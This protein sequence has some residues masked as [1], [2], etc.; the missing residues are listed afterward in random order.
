MTRTNAAGILTVLMRAVAVWMAAR[1]VLTWPGL[2]MSMS[3]Q[4]GEDNSI[5]WIA[6][7]ASVAAL[8]VAGAT[9]VFADVL[10]RLALA[11]PGQPPFESSLELPQWQ[12]LA[13]SVV[14]LWFVADAATGLATDGMVFLFFRSAAEYQGYFTTQFGRVAIYNGAEF[15][16]GMALLLRARGA[17]GLLRRLRGYES[18]PA[19]AVVDEETTG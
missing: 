11:R 12:E 8:G 2:I 6:I 14:G 16:I 4:L 7:G 17:V 1:L 3:Q 10:A 15:V 5:R 9:W 18:L 19:Q 13:F